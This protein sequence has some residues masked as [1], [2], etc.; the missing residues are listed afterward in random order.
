MMTWHFGVWGAGWAVFVA[1]LILLGILLL[2]WFFFLL[3]LRNLLNR[4]S[5]RNRAMPAGHVWLNFIPLFHLGWFPHTVIKVRDSVRN[6][7]VSRGGP[8]ANDLGYNVGIAAAVLFI[9]SFVLSWIP[10]VGW[11]I[12][13]AFLVCWII[14]WVRMAEHK[15]RFSQAGAWRDPAAPYGYPGPYGPP[16]G[17]PYGPPPVPPYVPP[18]GTN[19]FIAGY[20][21][22]PA[23]PQPPAA[24]QPPL[25]Q[26]PPSPVQAPQSVQPVPSEPPANPFPATGQQPP[27][28]GQSAWPAEQD[29]GTPVEAPTESQAQA[30]PVSCPACG[31]TSAPGDRFCR[32]C[33]Q[34]LA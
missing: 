3:N 11:G 1:V 4:V 5:D 26:T 9:A 30:R 12:N 13:V 2:P 33:G 28:T 31:A 18:A 19:P 6:E 24:P 32:T 10:V 7:Y 20:P 34:P 25:P 27:A 16:S 23:P 22:A 17:T 8:V 15:N 29:A 14:Y 21:A